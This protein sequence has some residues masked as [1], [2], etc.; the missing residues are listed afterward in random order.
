METKSL[1]DMRDEAERMEQGAYR[2]YLEAQKHAQDTGIRKLL[3]DLAIAEQGHSDVASMLEDKHLPEGAREEEDET[4]RRQFVLTYVQPGLAGLMDGSVSTLAPILLPPLPRRIRRRP[5][6]SASRPRWV[7]AFRWASPKPP[8]MTASSPVAV[9]RSSAA[10]LG[11][12]DR[13]LGGLGTRCP[14]SSRTS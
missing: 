1:D 3:G 13:A 9:R 5:S 2:F 4:A 6:S 12:H 14:I 8:M 10:S 11:H 7:L